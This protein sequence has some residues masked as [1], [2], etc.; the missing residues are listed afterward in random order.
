ML[1]KQLGWKQTY[2]YDLGVRNNRFSERLSKHFASAKLRSAILG[3]LL[4]FVWHDLAF[5]SLLH[6][7]WASFYDATEVLSLPTARSSMKLRQFP[8]PTYRRGPHQA[9]SCGYLPR[10]G[11]APSAVIGEHGDDER[12]A[13][14]DHAEWIGG[15]HST[16]VLCFSTSL[17]TSVLVICLFDQGCFVPEAPHRVY[18]TT[19]V[20]YTHLTLPTKR[21]V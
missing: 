3:V 1:A 2:R 20:S 18:C 12:L 5:L 21:I 11:V 4:W 14:S 7:L 17:R 19:S 15:D 16:T 8:P 9:R 13:P 10:Y 6:S